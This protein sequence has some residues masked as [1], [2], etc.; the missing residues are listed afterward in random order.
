MTTITVSSDNLKQACA[1]AID[2]LKKEHSD[3]VYLFR[4]ESE[5]MNAFEKITLDSHCSMGCVAKDIR[6]VD[7][8]AEA[9]VGLDICLSIDDFLLVKDYIED[10]L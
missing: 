3:W 8:L 2:V 4:E 7:K 6:S 9:C 1:K 5:G 10:G